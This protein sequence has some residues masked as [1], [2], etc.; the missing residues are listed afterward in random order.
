MFLR[1]VGTLREAYLLLRR[2]NAIVLEWGVDFVL[3]VRGSELWGGVPG[4]RF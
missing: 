2:D 3:Q 4:A 1:P